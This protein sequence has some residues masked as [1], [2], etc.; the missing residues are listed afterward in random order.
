MNRRSTTVSALAVAAIA[1]AACG[2]SPGPAPVRAPAAVNET[3]PIPDAGDAA[4]PPTYAESAAL[5]ALTPG[6]ETELTLRIARFPGRGE[7]TLWLAAYVGE[8][9]YGVALEDLELGDAMGV[10]PVES[11]DATFAVTGPA[12]AR[13]ECR[14]RHTA[15]MVCTVRAQALTH[16]SLHPPLGA[17]SIPLRVEA[18]FQARHAGDRARPGRLEIFGTVRATLETREGVRRFEGLGKY[19]EQTGDRP[20]FAGPF[21]YLAVQGEG[22]SLLARGGG[23]AIWGF[24]LLDGATATVTDFTIDPLG[25]P[26]RAFRAVLADGRTIEGTT[27]VVRETSVPIEGER[28]PSATV[29]ATT[30]LGPMTGHLND[31]HPPAREAE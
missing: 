21:T 10:T 22:E 16:E 23:G 14:E 5:V 6:G 12:E 20:S 25:S 1:A 30:N 17:G 7:A 24:A 26:A 13:I 8:H 27:E 29:R 3:A 9:R 18:E 31:W 11:R 28:R 4:V 15:A 19:H 2:P